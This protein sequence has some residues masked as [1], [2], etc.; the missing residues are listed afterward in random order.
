MSP[1]K[2]LALGVLDCSLGGIPSQVPSCCTLAID[3]VDGKGAGRSDQGQCDGDERGQ[4][5]PDP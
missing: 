5:D 3:D 2:K 4:A 1:I